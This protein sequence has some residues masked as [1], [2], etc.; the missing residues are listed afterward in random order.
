MNGFES[1]RYCSS[2][3]LYQMSLISLIDTLECS[4]D[5]LGLKNTQISSRSERLY[6]EFDLGKFVKNNRFG[7]FAK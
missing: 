4:R 3:L 6:L 1:L 7:H 5:P 2:D